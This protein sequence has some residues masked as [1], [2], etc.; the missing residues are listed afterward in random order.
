MAW[1]EV[2]QSLPSHRKTMLVSD[3]LNIAP[4]QVVGHLAC[5]WMWAL[6]NAPDGELGGLSNRLIA[7]AA[8]WLKDADAF[9]DALRA[10]GFL[11]G[12]TIHDWPD[13]AGRLV[14][15]R[16]QNRR[17]MRDARAAHEARTDDERA[18]H[19]QRTKDARAGAT[20]PNRINPL[21]PPAGGRKRKAKPEREHLTDEQRA[22]IVDDYATAFGSRAVA[23]EVIDTALAHEARLKSFNDNL[24]VRGW[25]RR[26][27]ERRPATALRLVHEQRPAPKFREVQ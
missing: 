10:A 16:E 7:R 1:I 21:S 27:A 20:Q 23:E 22:K 4:A 5:F 6:D 11:D 25:L 26:E 14:Q 12:S 9:A 24:Y 8:G 3:A 15:K 2:H 13:Y 17:R 19:V 18:T